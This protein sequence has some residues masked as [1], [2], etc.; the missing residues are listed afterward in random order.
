[1]DFG[2]L[3]E[4]ILQGARLQVMPELGPEGIARLRAGTPSSG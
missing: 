2:D 1:M 4:R 3:V